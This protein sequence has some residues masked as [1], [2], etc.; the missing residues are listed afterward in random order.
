MRRRFCLRCGIAGT[1]DLCGYCAELE[2]AESRVLLLRLGIGAGVLV[3]V[4]LQLLTNVGGA[5]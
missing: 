3:L 1:V 2:A 4:V 5:P